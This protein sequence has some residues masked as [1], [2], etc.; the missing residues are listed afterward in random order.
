MHFIN[1]ETAPYH[2]GI[3]FS[4][5]NGHSLTIVVLPKS[6]KPETLQINTGGYTSRHYTWSKDQHQGFLCLYEN[7]K[8][9]L[10]LS[11]KDEQD[12]P[13]MK[14]RKELLYNLLNSDKQ[15]TDKKNINLLITELAPNL[16]NNTEQLQELPSKSEA[17]SSIQSLYILLHRNNYYKDSSELFSMEQDNLLTPLT[18]LQFMTEV[19]DKYLF[20]KKGYLSVSEFTKNIRGRIDTNYLAKSEA[21]SAQKL[22]CHYDEFG[23]ETPF[24]RVILTALDMVSQGHP[25]SNDSIERTKDIHIGNTAQRA[26]QIR[27]FFNEIPSYPLKN[28]IFISK[29]F[30]LNKTKLHLKSLLLYAQTVLQ[31]KYLLLTEQKMQEISTWSWKVDMSKIWEKILFEGFSRNNNL[32]VMYYEDSIGDLSLYPQNSLPGAFGSN[33]THSNPDILLCFENGDSTI[34]WIIDAKYSYFSNK[35]SIPVNA[36]IEYRDQMFRYLFLMSKEQAVN[37]ERDFPNDAQIPWADQLALIY[38]TNVEQV[39]QGTSQPVQSIW[40][41]EWGDRPH[42]HQIALRFPSPKNV[43]SLQS[44][45]AYNLNTTNQLTAFIEQNR[46]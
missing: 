32:K 30:Q 14:L 38:T 29:H 16:L 11:P 46:P 17:I 3:A 35:E 8:V 33:N 42:L 23:L 6:W 24:L 26:L 15:N 22:F 13:L 44:W 37:P 40:L 9:R 18:H 21:F 2:T 5:K 12:H 28:A 7:E 39:Q 10:Y 34:N 31:Q 19:L 43:S 25:F 41:R 27:R 20:I 4:S 36:K 1:M 45:R